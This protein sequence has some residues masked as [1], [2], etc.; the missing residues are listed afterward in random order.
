MHV[1]KGAAQGSALKQSSDKAESLAS[2][3]THKPSDD[4]CTHRLIVADV[5][6]YLAFPTVSLCKGIHSF[7]TKANDYKMLGGPQRRPAAR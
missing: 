2:S 7:A 3:D 5:F 4:E 1:Q 6:D